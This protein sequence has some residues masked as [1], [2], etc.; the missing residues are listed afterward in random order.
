MV[1]P[2]LFLLLGKQLILQI[3]KIG[4]W[5]D[6]VQHTVEMNSPRF[7]RQSLAGSGTQL[8]GHLCL[9]LFS[10]LG[11]HFLEPIDSLALRVWR[12]ASGRLARGRVG[13]GGP[14]PN[15]P[16]LVRLFVFCI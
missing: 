11:P 13:L 5:K 4:P 10:S 14:N 1:C 15:S 9:T 3:G 16:L 2:L 6:W 8:Y 7:T 12:Y